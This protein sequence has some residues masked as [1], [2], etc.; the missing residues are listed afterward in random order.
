MLCSSAWLNWCGGRVVVRLAED[1]IGGVAEDAPFDRLSLPVLPQ[2]GQGLCNPLATLSGSAACQAEG[3]PRK[4]S[5]DYAR[6]DG[7]STC[8]VPA[9][10]QILSGE[11]VGPPTRREECEP[12]QR[13]RKDEQDQCDTVHGGRIPHRTSARSD[14]QETRCRRHFAGTERDEP[15]WPKIASGSGRLGSSPSPAA[16]GS[17][18][19]ASSCL[20]DSNELSGSARCRRL[21]RHDAL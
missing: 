16:S 6:G 14:G 2:I 15:S 19:H 21:G 4:T 9:A 10:L 11:E 13:Q 7:S 8:E 3:Q 12:S 20:C 1:E 5:S 18:A 17:P